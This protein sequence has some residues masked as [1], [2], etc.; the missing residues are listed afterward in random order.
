MFQSG[1][2]D[3]EGLDRNREKPAGRPVM[4]QTWHDLLFLHAMVSRDL[5]QE[6]VP[7][8]LTVEEYGGSAWLGFVPFRMSGIRPWG[9]PSLPWLSSFHETNIR[10]YV[11]HPKYGPGVWFFSLDAA[12]YL[13]C[14]IARHSFKLPYFHSRLSIKIGDRDLHY[15]GRRNSTQILPQVGVRTS[16]LVNYSISATNEGMWHNA[17]PK[18]LEYWLLERYRLYSVGTNGEIV[19]ARVHHE[20]YR[21][22]NASVHE[23]AIDGLEDQFGQLKFTNAL[24]VERVNVQCFSPHPV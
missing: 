23:I 6:M 12:R 16:N 18:K 19:T 4:R 15:R 13:G 8:E 7:P 5:L 21:I 9:F 11:T 2:P 22:E 20:P 24:F 1:I 3:W 14:L 17:K 10:T